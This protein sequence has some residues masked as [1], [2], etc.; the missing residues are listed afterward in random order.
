MEEWFCGGIV[1]PASVTRRIGGVGGGEE[2]CVE[3]DV[4]DVNDLDVRAVC[5]ASNGRAL[6]V[7]GTD[8]GVGLDVKADAGD[9]AICP[10]T[11]GL[12]AAPS[13]S[14]LDIGGEHK[15]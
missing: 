5:K 1:C 7:G 6:S 14:V 15:S 13:N 9:I 2:G 12:L 3:H 11:F 4:L 8:A 10:S